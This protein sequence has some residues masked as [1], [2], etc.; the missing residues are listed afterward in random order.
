MHSK[1]RELCEMMMM[2]MGGGGG[3]G[4][5]GEES[6]RRSDKRKRKYQFVPHLF[7][8]REVQ[9]FGIQCRNTPENI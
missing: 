8:S 3:G 1:K 7:S 5:G 2:M 4:G 9:G 6:S